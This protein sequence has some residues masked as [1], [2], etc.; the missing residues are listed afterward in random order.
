MQKVVRKC[1][2]K[3]KFGGYRKITA[4]TA[5]GYPGLS[6]R[7]VQKVT[8]SDPNIRKSNVRFTKKATHT[9]VMA[10]EVSKHL[11]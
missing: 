1:F 2:A 5:D 9:P 11:L 3:N 4:R 10:K 6:Q 7:Q 8:Q